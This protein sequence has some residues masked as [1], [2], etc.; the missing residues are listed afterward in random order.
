MLSQLSADVRGVTLA[1]PIANG[2]IINAL[3]ESRK[4]PKYR[5]VVSVMDADAISE[6]L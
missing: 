1:L 6:A 4:Q 3:P 2:L 5:H